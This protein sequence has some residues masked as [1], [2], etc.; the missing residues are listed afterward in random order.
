MLRAGKVLTFDEVEQLND[1]EGVVQFS[2]WLD[3]KVSCPTREAKRKLLHAFR[4]ACKAARMEQAEDEDS[5]VP[6]VWNQGGIELSTRLQM[7]S[8]SWASSASC[9]QNLKR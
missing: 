8:C 2:T 6:L 7:R 5:L 9:A 4:Q 1:M 3:A